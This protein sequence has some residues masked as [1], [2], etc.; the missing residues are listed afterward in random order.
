V[1]QGLHGRIKGCWSQLDEA[2]A[3]LVPR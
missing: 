1:R 3:A 2:R